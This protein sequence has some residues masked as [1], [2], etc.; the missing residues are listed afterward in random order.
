MKTKFLGK[1]KNKSKRTSKI[2]L[3]CIPRIKE[4]IKYG[5]DIWN[6]YDFMHLDK[7][8]IPYLS[9]LELSLIHI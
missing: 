9:V 3:D 7:N 6:V 8:M 1:T 4:C 5:V 2:L